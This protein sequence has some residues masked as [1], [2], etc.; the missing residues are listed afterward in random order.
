MSQETMWQMVN[1]LT[2]EEVELDYFSAY[3]LYRENKDKIYNLLKEHFPYIDWV[4]HVVLNDPNEYEVDRYWFTAHVSN[5]ALNHTN[6][7]CMRRNICVK[8]ASFLQDQ[9]LIDV[10]REIDYAV[11]LVEIADMVQAPRLQCDECRTFHE[12]CK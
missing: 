3:H 8:T 9:W 10:R 7:S 1:L 2:G 6:C 4:K 5:P 11:R 12:K